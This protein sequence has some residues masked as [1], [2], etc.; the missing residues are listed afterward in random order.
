[1]HFGLRLPCSRWATRRRRSEE[2]GA[3][4]GAPRTRASDRVLIDHLLVAARVSDHVAGADPAARH[5]VGVTDDPARTL[6]LVLPF[7]EPSVRKQWATLDHLSAGDFLGV[8]VG[9]MEAEFEAVGIHTAARRA[10]ERA[11]Q[12]DHGAW[13]QD[14]VTYEGRFY[15]AN[16]LSIDPKPAQRPHPPIWIGGGTQPSEKIYGQKVPTVEPV[17]RR[18]AKYA[19][20]WV[21]HS[22]ATAEM[23]DRDW[24]D[25]RRYML[26]YGRQPEEMSRVYSNFVHV[27][28]PGERPEDAAPLFRVYSGMDL[29]YW[30]RY[31]LLGEEEGRGPDPGQGR[32]AGRRRPPRAQPAGGT[33]GTSSGSRATSCQALV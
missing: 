10:D 2:M 8:G 26:E 18:I 15:R 11:A 7:R 22:S 9:W 16:D 17:L 6:V 29:D 32:G 27:L 3:T 33:R 13:T 24:D 20:T 31:Y 21:P 5:A 4:C 28:K 30:Q 1:M 25:L 12:A 19:K 23:V 14:H